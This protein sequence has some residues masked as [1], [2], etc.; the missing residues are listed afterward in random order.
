MTGKLPENK[1]RFSFVCVF[2]DLMKDSQGRVNALI[3]FNEKNE[4]YFESLTFT[5]EEPR[6]MIIKVTESEDSLL[7]SEP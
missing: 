6:H 4:A 3:I 2:R 7:E 5:M 1:R